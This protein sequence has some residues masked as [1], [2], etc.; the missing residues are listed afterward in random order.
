MKTISKTIGTAAV[1]L[2]LFLSQG[3]A[4][5]QFFTSGSDPASTKWNTIQTDNYKLLYPRGLDSLATA[6]IQNLEYWRD[7]VGASV[8]YKPGER[9]TNPTPVILHP[10]TATSNGAVVWAPRRMDLFTCPNLSDPEPMPWMQNLGV[11]ESRHVAQMQFGRSG[12]F[13]G[14]HFVLGEMFAGAAAAIYPSTALLEGD[15]VTAETALTSAGRGRSDAF[16]RQYRISLDNGDFRNWWQWRYGSQKKYTPDH[17][18]AGY[19]AI[20][21]ARYAF[22]TPHFTDHYFDRIRRRAGFA[23]WNWQKT[24]RELSGEDTFTDAFNKVSDTYADVWREYDSHRSIQALPKTRLT[25][26]GRFYAKYTNMAAAPDGIYVVKT[27]LDKAAELHFIDSTGKD[28]FVRP[29]SSSVGRLV[30]HDNKLYWSENTPGLRW[31]LGGD[32]SI[33]YIKHHGR[34]IHDVTRKG[35]L[36]NPSFRGE[37]LLAIDCRYDGSSTIMGGPQAPKGVQI[38]ELAS[39]GKR[40]Y[41][42]GLNDEGL[43]LYLYDGGWKTVLTP[44]KVRLHT[45][46][47]SDGTLYFVSDLDGTDEVYSLSGKSLK[48]LTNYK[49]GASDY[50]LRGSTIYLTIPGTDGE[51]L[52]SEDLNALKGEDADWNDV[53]VSPIVKK[54]VAQSAGL[55]PEGLTDGNTEI[56]S[57]KKYSKIAG[58]PHVH[59]WAPVYLHGDDDGTLSF[60]ETTEALRFGAT[61]FFQNLLGTAWGT[62]A[63]GCQHSHGNN[64]YRTIGNISFT[65]R[66]WFPVLTASVTFNEEDALAYTRY[67]ITSDGKNWISTTGKVQNKTSFEANIK[68]Y[69]PF[70]LSSG[71]WSRGITPMVKAC[72][73]NNTFDKSLY[74]TYMTGQPFPGTTYGVD[75]G[76]T[77]NVRMVTSS[78]TAYAKRPVPNSAIYPRWGAGVEV[79]YRF[80]PGLDDFFSPG[81]YAY[82]YGYV[83]GLLS[84]HGIKLSA[85]WQRLDAGMMREN[86]VTTRPRG[87][88]DTGI[89]SYLAL[90]QKS[91]FK[92]TIDYALPLLSV[93]WGGLS[94]I[95]YVR[96]FELIPHYDL[97]L[98]SKGSLTTAGIDIMARLENLLWLPY[99]S[100][101]GISINFNGGSAYDKIKNDADLKKTYVKAILSVDL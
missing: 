42:I 79:G 84:T 51:H 71:G 11:H 95:V 58:I 69:V 97:A 39:D 22:D 36:F 34:K 23:F 87:F 13:T 100:K 26:H 19:F 27:S 88:A 43:G 15:A 86:A 76:E 44:S 80:R 83:P 12:F 33:R 45:L 98:L 60:Q 17:Y 52:Y 3:N 67:H 48:K 20:S 63:I 29:M 49:Y 73:T 46:D 68:A 47:I 9:Y 77:S 70:N 4:N 99:T 30:F 38:I 82:A 94:P 2:S 53:Y 81:L 90:N 1:C 57:P 35:R 31:E 65:W 72:F 96:N 55:L 92:A 28:N 93:D 7:R 89:N 18:A 37:S 50:C 91:Q 5:A 32:S 61:A 78:V 6:Y 21:G 41:A 59:S 25:R 10:F 8:G 75:K 62:A 14:I 24:F 40:I 64:D 16:L 101:F 66:G 54:I 85:I 56:S 74:Y